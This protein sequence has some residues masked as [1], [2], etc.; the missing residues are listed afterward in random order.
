MAAPSV[1]RMRLHIGFPIRQRRPLV[2][3]ACAASARTRAWAPAISR[4]GVASRIRFHIHHVE[5]VAPSD[6]T[7][8]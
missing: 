6:Q 7:T 1:P 2:R 3:T 8:K 4:A 5:M